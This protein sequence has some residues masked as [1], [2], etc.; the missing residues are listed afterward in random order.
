MT[1]L[2]KI[3]AYGLGFKTDSDLPDV[4]ITALSEG[5]DSPA[6]RILAGRSEADNRFLLYSEYKAWLS[7]MNLVEPGKAEAASVY[8]SFFV[9]QIVA[10]ITDP[11][12]GFDYI[13]TKILGRL[14]LD[15]EDFGFRQ[16]YTLYITLWET[17]TDGLR[18]FDEAVYTNEEFVTVT[19]GL[20]VEEL[21]LWLSTVVGT[22]NLLQS[23]IR[24]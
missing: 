23:T 18:M 11:Y 16:A 9:Q 1:L 3:S 14:G 20:L 10:G 15:Y 8:I 17:L 19:K 6:L 4:A 21:K 24:E 2:E 22:F 5:Y 13:Y 12:D 7:E